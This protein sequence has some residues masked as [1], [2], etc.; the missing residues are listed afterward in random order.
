MSKILIKE[1]ELIK[2][3]SETTKKVM[4]EYYGDNGD[5]DTEAAIAIHDRIFGR[6][7]EY[8][9]RDFVDTLI[10]IIDYSRNSDLSSGRIANAVATELAKRA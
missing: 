7:K 8:G 6:E 3:V 1:S 9:P 10:S 2:L 5:G 4:K